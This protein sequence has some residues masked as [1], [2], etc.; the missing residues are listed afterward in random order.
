MDESV[1]APLNYL[2]ERVH[3]LETWAYDPPDGRPR[4]NGKL[5]AYPVK[6]RNARACVEGISS[7]HGFGCLHRPSIASDFCN[8]EVIRTKVYAETAEWVKDALQASSVVV[9]DHTYRRRLTHRPPLDGTGGSF[10]TIRT[11]VGRVH[12]D[13]TP[14]S[15]PRRIASLFGQNPDDP[16]PPYRIFGVWRPLNQRPLQDAP[17]ALAAAY[18]VTSDELVANAIVYPERRGETYAVLHNKHHQWFYFP[19]MER[20]E[21]LLFLHYDSVCSEHPAVPHTAFEDPGSP[22]DAE[23]RESLELRMLVL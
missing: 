6:I 11:P 3:P 10:S 12:S 8:N 18:S 13:F 5:R 15:A 7:E 23:P 19:E 21:I 14:F 9:F 20:D 1:I 2:A 4:F 16:L 22:P 17:L